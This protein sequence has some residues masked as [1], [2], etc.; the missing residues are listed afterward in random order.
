M[1]NILYLLFLVAVSPHGMAQS[2][3]DN[4][5][6]IGFNVNVLLNKVVFKKDN[7]DPNQNLRVPDDQLT[8]FTFRHFTTPKSGFRFGFGYYKDTRRDSLNS[9]FFLST[10]V[11]KISY[12]SFRMG[13]QKRLNISKR[14]K[15]YFG[16]DFIYQ[17]EKLEI[18]NTQSS[19]GGGFDWYFESN[20]V[21]L[22][23][24]FGLGIP[25][26]VQIFVTD[27]ISLSTESNLEF[28]R[29]KIKN[30]FEEIGDNGNINN[31]QTTKS[32]SYKVNWRLP[33]SVFINYSF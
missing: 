25:I 2:D 12:V 33:L 1:K 22:T 30:D 5:N 10:S 20:N 3:L 8:N 7:D 28:F 32:N 29:E 15:P 6:E 9:G 31:S 14:L 21:D 18:D 19:T 13:G 11:H 4:K 17:F 23:N 16:L 27:K 24:R 26:G